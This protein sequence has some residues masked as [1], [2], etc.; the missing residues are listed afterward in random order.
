[1]STTPFLQCE[2]VRSFFIKLSFNTYY[3]H[4]FEQQVLPMPLFPIR[5]TEE[6]SDIFHDD[7]HRE[8]NT[9]LKSPKHACYES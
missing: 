3:H 6:N 4:L 1:M 7:L 5:T 8:V 9:N 2:C